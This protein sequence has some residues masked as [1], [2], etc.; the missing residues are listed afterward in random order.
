MSVPKLIFAELGIPPRA[1]ALP[2]SVV[3]RPAFRNTQSTI[4]A[5]RNDHDRVTAAEFEQELRLCQLD[6]WGEQCKAAEICGVGESAVRAWRTGKQ[7]PPRRAIV[8]LREWRSQNSQALR[9]VGGAK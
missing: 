6:R 9:V 5:M 2:L 8:A 3:E 4:R 1:K 7:L